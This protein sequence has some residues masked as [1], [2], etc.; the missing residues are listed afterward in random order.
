MTTLSNIALYAGGALIFATVLVSLAH[1]QWYY[2]KV[3]RRMRN[4]RKLRRR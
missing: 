1:Q 3:N 4:L 2:I